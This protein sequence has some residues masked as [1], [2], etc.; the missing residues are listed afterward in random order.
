MG[1]MSSGAFSIDQL[2]ELAGLAVSQSKSPNILVA[3]GPGNNGGDGLVAARHLYH[4][5]YAPTVVYPKR[6]GKQL[7][8]N[9]VTQ[10]EQLHIPILAELPGDF[11]HNFDVALD[12]IFGFSFK[13]EPRPPFASM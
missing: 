4:F 10:C 3:C 11:P 5:G 9:L 7:F 12:A 6:P 8:V 2:M 1:L 13:G